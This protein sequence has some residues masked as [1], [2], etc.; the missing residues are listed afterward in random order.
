MKGSGVCHITSKFSLKSIFIRLILK[1]EPHWHLMSLLRYDMCYMARALLS[2][3][4]GEAK[5]IMMPFP[6]ASW[7]GSQICSRACRQQ[8]VNNTWVIS[9]VTCQQYCASLQSCGWGLVAGQEAN[10]QQTWKGAMQNALPTVLALAFSRGAFSASLGWECSPHLFSFCSYHFPY[11]WNCSVV[12]PRTDFI[13]LLY[14]LFVFVFF[15]EGIRTTP[16]EK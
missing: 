8:S 3:L 16:L 7:W 9:P 14:F 6:V 4:Q 15:W 11:P 5:I 12:S 1:K 13:K 2:F 10:H